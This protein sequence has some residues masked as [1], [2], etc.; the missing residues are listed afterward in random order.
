MNDY[1]TGQILYANTKLDNK[2]IKI[3]MVITEVVEI[4]EEEYNKTK[5]EA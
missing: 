2:F 3:K 1:K 4:S 5:N